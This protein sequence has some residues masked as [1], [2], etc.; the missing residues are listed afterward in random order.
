M[1]SGASARV[2]VIQLKRVGDVLLCTPLLR[3]LRADWPERRIAFLTEAPNAPLLRGNPNCDAVLT[4]P[5]SMGPADW[6]ALRAAVRG[7]QPGIVVDLSGT[8]RSCM[9]TWLSGAPV[10]VGF[11]VRRPRSWVYNIAETPDRNKYTVDRRLDLLRAIGIEGR[12]FATEL[13][14]AAEERREAERLLRTAGFPG[15][16][17]LLGFAPTSRK[18]EKRWSPEGFASLAIWAREELHA[19]ILLLRGPGEGEQEDEIRRILPFHVPRLEGTPP[20][21]VLAALIERCR[22]LVANDGG[23]KH[24]AASLGVR[25]VT[26]FVSTGPASWHPP[27]DR[28]HAAVIAGEGLAT[29]IREAR[30]A[31]W[32]LWNGFEEA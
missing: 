24:M 29:E 13:Y 3:A 16:V 1:A 10:R 8:P 28:R 6:V 5:P 18:N 12:G 23:A 22:V 21:R 26:V 19:E 7:E 2:L 30:D 11:R 4:I 20:L 27:A 25:T 32:R 14:L 17:P 15:D 9:I 31:L